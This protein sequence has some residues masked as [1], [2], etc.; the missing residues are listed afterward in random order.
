MIS[1]PEKTFPGTAT[2]GKDIPL[3]KNF[4]AGYV[5]FPVKIARIC[6]VF[7]YLQATPPDSDL[8]KKGAG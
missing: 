5:S 1:F 7:R 8:A 6:V 3:V 2:R 4:N